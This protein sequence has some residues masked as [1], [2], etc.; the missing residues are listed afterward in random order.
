MS[1][2]LCRLEQPHFDLTESFLLSL[3]ESVHLERI[4]LILKDGKMKIAGPQHIS[5]LF[6][7][8]NGEKRDCTFIEHCMRI[9]TKEM[10]SL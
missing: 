4:C 9:W 1:S 2:I 7:K 3:G 8:V 10:F 5:Y 6:E